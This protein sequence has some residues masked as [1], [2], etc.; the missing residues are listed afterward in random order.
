MTLRKIIDKSLEWLLVFLLSILVIDVLWQVASRYVLN[1]P[2]SYTDEL[3]GYLLIWVGLLGAAYVAG[4][5][6]HLAID[7]LIQRSSPKRKLRME[8][9]I[10]I[11]VILFAV[12]VLII[13]GIWLVY[14]RFYLSVKSAALGMPLGFVY[15]VLPLSGLL[16]AYFDIDNMRNIITSYRKTN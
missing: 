3:A 14:T 12:S 5:R 16:I 13:G 8:I 7:I 2:S 9:I 15:L 6:E 11:L 10:S 4:K 1:S